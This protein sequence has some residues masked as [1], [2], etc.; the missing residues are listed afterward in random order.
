MTEK[1][2]YNARILDTY[3]KLIKV[4]YPHVDINTLVK[5]SGM[6]PYEVADQGSWF[7]QEQV[8]RFYELVVQA[9]GNEN[10]AREAGRYGASPDALGSMRQ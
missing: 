2:I 4:R 7:T 6:E 10:I 5:R 9:T 3:L 8:N 1:R